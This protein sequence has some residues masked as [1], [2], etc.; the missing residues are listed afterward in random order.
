MARTRDRGY[1][2]GDTWKTFHI[3]AE[4]RI[5]FG[6]LRAKRPRPSVQMVSADYCRREV[7]SVGWR[8]HQYSLRPDETF[9][10]K[11]FGKTV[12]YRAERCVRFGISILTA[13]ELDK[14]DRRRTLPIHARC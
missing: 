11:A 3:S 5:L 7:P 6:A 12:V 10:R 4:P 1:W 8:L 14:I 9:C 2:E 13:Q